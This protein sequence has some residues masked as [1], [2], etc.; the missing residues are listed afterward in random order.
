[1]KNQREGCF[2]DPSASPE[3]TKTKKRNERKK[4]DAGKL[5]LFSEMPQSSG[6]PPGAGARPGFQPLAFAPAAPEDSY[7]GYLPR[8]ARN[9]GYRTP[10]YGGGGG[11]G[12]GGRGGGSFVSS[13]SSASMPRENFVSSFPSSYPLPPP[14]ATPEARIDQLLDRISPTEETD[15]ARAAVFAFLRSVIDRCFSECKVRRRRREKKKTKN[16]D[17]REERKKSIHGSFP[18]RRA[19][20]RVPFDPQRYSGGVRDYPA[21][22]H[23][24]K[25]SK[26]REHDRTR[27]L[28]TIQLQQ[29]KKG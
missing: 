13:A 20:A 7:Q 9:G 26:K 4:T 22:L 15:A 27:G 6:P 12:R 28:A 2:F 14:P 25:R 11:R 24:F 8:R 16:A 3:N 23:V 21:S 5:L 29:T 17:E 10:G 18:S 19:R 1:M